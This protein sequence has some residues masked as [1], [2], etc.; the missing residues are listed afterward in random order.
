[1]PSCRAHVLLKPSGENWFCGPG[2]A[3]PSPAS[4][5]LLKLFPQLECHYSVTCLNPAIL[6][7]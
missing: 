5:P 3:F 6:A 1:M 7:L 4:R 2:R